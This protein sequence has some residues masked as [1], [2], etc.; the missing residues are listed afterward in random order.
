MA[1]DKILVSQII[2]GQMLIKMTI[3]NQIPF[4][5]TAIINCLPTVHG[6]EPGDDGILLHVPCKQTLATVA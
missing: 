3:R 5:R 2:T 6:G 1:K 4:N